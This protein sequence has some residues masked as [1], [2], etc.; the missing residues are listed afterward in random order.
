MKHVR[1][2]LEYDT[3]SDKRHNRPNGNVF[4]AFVGN[5]SF[6][7]GNNICYEG[8]GAI[9]FQPNSPVASTAASLDVI[10][11]RFKR[12]A[13]AQA[14]LVHPALFERLDTEANDAT[15]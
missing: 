7:S 11:T 14:R 8:L 12:V 15:D 1:F 2:Y 13:E 4:A 3:P 10:R 5:G 6:C 9:F